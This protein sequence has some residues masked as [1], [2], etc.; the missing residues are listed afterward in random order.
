MDE[1]LDIGVAAVIDI[2]SLA[3]PDDAA[4]LCLCAL[5]RT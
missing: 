3:L 1:L 2:G 4:L 5:C